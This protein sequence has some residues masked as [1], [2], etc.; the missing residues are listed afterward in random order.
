MP[1]PQPSISIRNWV[2]NLLLDSC[3][4]SDLRWRTLRLYKNMLDSYKTFLRGTVKESLHPTCD[5]RES[6]SSMNI[7]AGWR[8]LATPKRA[9]T[10]FSPSPI[11]R[12]TQCLSNTLNLSPYYE[13]LNKR[14]LRQQT[15]LLV[16]ELAEIE[17]NVAFASPA[18]ALPIIV[19]PV[20]WKHPSYVLNVCAK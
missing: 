10:N 20:P 7:T 2:F 8:Q 14:F 9:R 13:V 12:I 3:S 16:R 1:L 4:P 11:C 17:K 6:I 19:F 5:K 15:H 18:M